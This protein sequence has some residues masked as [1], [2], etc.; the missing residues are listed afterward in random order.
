MNGSN[1][2]RDGYIDTRTNQPFTPE[3]IKQKWDNIGEYS[4]NYGTWVH[5]NIER[6]LNHKVCL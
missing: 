3:Q 1:W 6:Y 5:Y 4:R 2:P